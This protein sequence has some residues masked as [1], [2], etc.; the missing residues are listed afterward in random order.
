M[1]EENKKIN[2]TEIE[3]ETETEEVITETETDTE[4]ETEKPKKSFNLRKLKRGG[5]SVIVTAIFIA[6]VVL[7]NIIVNTLLIRFDVR[8]DL[9][10]Q[11]LFSIDESTANY[12]ASLDDTINIYFCAEEEEFTSRPFY[13]QV[14]EIAARFSEA[15]KNI[16]IHFVDRL[17]NPTFA[18]NYGGNL[19][20][21][22]VII[23]SERTGRYRIIGT[24]EYIIREIFYQG[25][26]ISEQEANNISM[27]TQGT[28]PIETT[29]YAGAERAFLSAIM[30]VS[31]LS[32]SRVGLAYG[33]GQGLNEH[34]NTMALATLLGIMELLDAN[35]YSVEAVDMFLTEEIDPE[36][37]F[38]II[39]APT[40]DFSSAS[41]EKINKWLENNMMYGKTLIYFPANR[42]I[43]ATPNLDTYLAEWWGLQVE[44]Y[45]IS[46]QNQNVASPGTRGMEQFILAVADFTTGVNENFLGAN[47]RPVTLLFEQ[48]GSTSTFPLLVTYQGAM[49]L[50]FPDNGVEYTEDEVP[51]VIGPAVFC[52]AGMSRK[53]YI[54]RG[55]ARNAHVIVFGAPEIFAPP[56]IE[57]VQL[58][59]ARFLLNIFN[60][61]SGRDEN[62]VHI[63]PPSYHPPTFDITARQ[64]YTISLFFVIIIPLLIIAAGLV[65]F[66]RRRYR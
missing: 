32:P 25:R 52:V 40:E 8:F 55:E 4:N 13:F 61:L 23:E 65:V 14:T 3:T 24:E 2:E 35:S 34:E 63:R 42:D 39:F 31:D 28:A 36:I 21:S 53:R 49:A 26:R 16:N 64:A 6:A 43:R 58:T 1:S 29:F 15:N 62:T 38:L 11:K 7:I 10:R 48:D 5:F 59:N 20:D 60:E 12:L 27:W 66:F 44:N 54:D 33:L 47:M 41:I 9:T 19:A 18:A 46:Q 30:S 57:S 50:A 37:D 22:D 51:D 56:Y 17:S 45:L